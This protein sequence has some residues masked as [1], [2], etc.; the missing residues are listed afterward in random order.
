MFVHRG[1]LEPAL[2]AADY[3]DPEVY[4]HEQRALFSSHW[5]LVGA[6]EVLCRPGGQVAL[7]L[8]GTPVVVRSDQQGLVAFR[9]VCPHR[10]SLIVAPGEHVAETLQCQYHGWQ[11]RPDGSLLKLPDGA[12]FRG[13]K[14]REICLERY[15]VERLGPLV[16]VS[17]TA[18]GPSLRDT[19][20]PI[21]TELEQA[22]EGTQLAIGQRSGHA[23]NWKIPVENAVE[24]YHVPL[25]HPSTF[26][27]YLP[28]EL[29][30]HEL[31][32]TYSRYRPT[33]PPSWREQLAFAG[34]GV[35]LRSSR[36]RRYQHIH[37]LPNYLIT[38]SGIY[39][40]VGEIVPLAV[41]RCRRDMYGFLPSDVRKNP[42]SIALDEVH[43]RLLRRGA[44][45][46]LAEDSSVWP[47]VQA[48]SG[49]SVGPGV[50]GA[51][52]ER[53]YHFQR[54]VAARLGRAERAVP[55]VTAQ[56]RE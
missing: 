4:A 14:A 28:E 50:L 22:L 17:L 35:M 37:V 33:A 5:H 45:A 29:H 51:R 34:F 13:L 15:R 20:G 11:F 9:N 38:Y 49:H 1:K 6:H 23:A 54:Y 8:Q 3:V 2:A 55:V 18:T 44:D 53:V 27:S 12:S 52:E 26:Q 48:G 56:T 32:P 43:R 41:D 16:F 46:I 7:E 30:H 39:V 24:S 42:V 21:Y 31:E 19:F 10:H 36:A 47:H 25:V 40:E